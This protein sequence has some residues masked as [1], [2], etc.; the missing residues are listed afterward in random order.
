MPNNLLKI[1]EESIAD[2]AKIEEKKSLGDDYD[3]HLA[4]TIE[5]KMLAAQRHGAR[6]SA[7]NRNIL[8]RPLDEKI[9]LD[10]ETPVYDQTRYRLYGC[11]SGPTRAERDEQV[12]RQEIYTVKDEFW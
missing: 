9:V 5:N 12:T 4:I 6:I 3:Y 2:L 11:I 1:I 10:S 7:T 8:V